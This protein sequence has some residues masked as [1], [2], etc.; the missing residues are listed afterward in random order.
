MSGTR[1]SRFCKNHHNFVVLLLLSWGLNVAAAPLGM[2]SDNHSDRLS[3][4]NA[5]L[6]IVTAS[7][8]ARPGMALGDCVVSADERTGITTSSGGAIT[9]I[10]LENGVMASDDNSDLDISN[11]GVDMA[12]S[13][14]DRFLVLAGGGALQQPLSVVSTAT[15]EEIATSSP[16]AD[17]TSVE[18]CDDGTLLVTTT[19]GKYFDW[20]VDNAMYDARLAQD[21][22]V[23]TLGHRLSSGARPN[24]ASCAPGSLSGVLLDRQGGLP[25][26]TLPGLV[27]AQHVQLTSPEAIASV[28]SKDG[29]KLFIR[30]NNALESYHFNPVTGEMQRDWVRQMPETEPYYGI[31]QIAIHPDGN[32]LYVDGGKAMLIINP[33][34]GAQLGEFSLG[35]TTGICFANDPGPPVSAPIAMD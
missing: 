24:N 18:F 1:H 26:F 21:G 5:D 27:P 17:H 13:P 29:R 16:F 9:F 3:I 30:T 6:D 14:D 28:F 7:L 12:L 33:G 10:S 19:Q 8:A 35:D 25:S 11:L 34:D 20:Q 31:D 2:V 15:R 4:F 23:E 32:K 22:K